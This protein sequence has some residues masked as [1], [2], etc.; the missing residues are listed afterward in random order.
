MNI[1]DRD[2]LDINI[3]NNFIHNIIFMISRIKNQ[4]NKSTHGCTFHNNIPKTWKLSDYNKDMM[5][6]FISE[7]EY[8]LHNSIFIKRK[9]KGDNG[10]MKYM[11]DAKVAPY[12]QELYNY[13]KPYIENIDLIVGK[14]DNLFTKDYASYLIKYIFVL[15][16]R[17][18]VEF[19]N[20]ENE[21][22]EDSECKGGNEIFQSLE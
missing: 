13:I 16:L 19:I 2:D 20:I 18:I 11:L 5:S 21:D 8:L 7:N 1:I 12:F 9:N 22:N 10:F 3:I 14:Q 6:D 17:K 4:T 15:I